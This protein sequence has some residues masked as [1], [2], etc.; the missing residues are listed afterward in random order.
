[1][2]PFKGSDRLDMDMVVKRK[3]QLCKEI[4]Q[5]SFET[6]E[7]FLMC[8]KTSHRS[9]INSEKNSLQ[10]CALTSTTMSSRSLLLN[11]LSID[12]TEFLIIKAEYLILKTT[13]VCT[14]V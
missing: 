6:Y 12:D 13:L 7:T 5:D 2:V 11:L 14:Q 3:V 4:F 9:Q 10:Y 8:I 1:M